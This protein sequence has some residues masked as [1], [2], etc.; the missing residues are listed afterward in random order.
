[1]FGWLVYFGQLGRQLVGVLLTMMVPRL[2]L[3][4]LDGLLVVV[5]VSLFRHG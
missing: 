3:D 4:K 1:M 2:V 5:E